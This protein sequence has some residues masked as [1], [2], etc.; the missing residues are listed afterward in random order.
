MSHQTTGYCWRTR[1]GR[2]LCIPHAFLEGK[3]AWETYAR[4]STTRTLKLIR[5]QYPPVICTGDAR[6]H[7]T[8]TPR[9]ETQSIYQRRVGGWLRSFWAVRARESFVARVIT[10]HFP[11]DA[12]TRPSRTYH[13]Q[14]ERS[15]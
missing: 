10:V 5:Q 13:D 2:N 9:T 6:D 1:K 8:G 15:R 12:A 14:R 3:K 11:P 7:P 4:K